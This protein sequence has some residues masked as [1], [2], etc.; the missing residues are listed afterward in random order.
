MHDSRSYSKSYV[1]CWPGERA[2]KGSYSSSTCPP[3]LVASTSSFGFFV[4]TAFLSTLEASLQDNR[5]RKRLQRRDCRSIP[6]ERSSL[7]NRGKLSD[8]TS[9]PCH[10]EAAKLQERELERSG[11]WKIR[12]PGLRRFPF[13]SSLAS[14]VRG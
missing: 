1:F 11:R 5:S 3:P 4:A 6:N 10:A 13:S 7:A 2:A 12:L 8:F 14:N 9:H